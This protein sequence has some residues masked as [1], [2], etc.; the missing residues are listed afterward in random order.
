M[1]TKKTIIAKLL[2]KI[3]NTMKVVTTKIIMITMIMTRLA[4]H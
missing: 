1:I 3:Y 2:W 4:W